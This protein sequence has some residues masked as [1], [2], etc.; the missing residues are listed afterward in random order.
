MDKNPLAISAIFLLFFQL[1]TPI[2][3]AGFDS[4]TV[5][6]SDG[7]KQITLNAQGEPVEL[8]NNTQHCDLCI[9]Y[10]PQAPTTLTAEASLSAAN[11]II[12]QPYI[13]AYSAIENAQKTGFSSRAPPATP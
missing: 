7:V 2:A 6:G 11:T 1:L 13:A 12:T 8:P 9:L 3:F 10:S 4:I 5:C